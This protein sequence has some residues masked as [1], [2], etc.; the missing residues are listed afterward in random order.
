MSTDR[1]EP[2]TEHLGYEWH[3]LRHGDF[4]LPVRFESTGRPDIEPLWLLPNYHATPAW[5]HRAGWRYVA[6]AVPPEV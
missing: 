3:W 6:P 1:C 2:P 4:K 5:A